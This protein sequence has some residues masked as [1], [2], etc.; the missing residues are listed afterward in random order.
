MDP[1]E[2]QDAAYNMVV[3]LWDGLSPFRRLAFIIWSFLIGT[4]VEPGLAQAVRYTRQLGFESWRRFFFSQKGRWTAYRDMI[5]QSS[6]R[7]RYKIL[8]RRMLRAKLSMPLRTE[9]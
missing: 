5:A 6:A 1:V 7:T 9:D 8:D 3:A 2:I 4:K